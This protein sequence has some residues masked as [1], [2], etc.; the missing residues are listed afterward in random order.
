M[1]YVGSAIVQPG[2]IWVVAIGLAF[3]AFLSGTNAWLCVRRLTRS[4]RRARGRINQAAD[5]LQFR[6]QALSLNIIPQLSMMIPYL[7]ALLLMV[8]WRGEA[9]APAEDGKPYFRE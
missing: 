5:A 6:L 2:T 1:D 9:I 7:V 3:W 4:L 8:L